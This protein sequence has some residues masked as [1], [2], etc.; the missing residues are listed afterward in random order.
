MAWMREPRVAGLRP[1]SPA[2]GRPA[3]RSVNGPAKILALQRL[4]GNS[5]V[6]EIFHRERNGGDGVA[7]LQRSDDERFIDDDL[8]ADYRT[9]IAWGEG[10]A[11][12]S[13]GTVTA[14]APSAG[15]A[16]T[17]APSAGT[18]TAPPRPWAAMADAA[19]AG[20]D[21]YMSVDE[22][23]RLFDGVKDREFLSTKGWM[24]EIP[25]DQAELYCADRASHIALQLT[26]VGVACKRIY[27]VKTLTDGAEGLWVNSTTAPGARPGVPVTLR[28]DYHVAVAVDVQDAAGTH[29]E[30]IFDPAVA[31]GG[32][33]FL[34]QWLQA[35]H[36]D[37]EAPH[38]NR[39]GESHQHATE[40]LQQLR[41]DDP[42]APVNRMG[43]PLGRTWV[44]ATEP[45][46]VNIP[47]VDS[48]GNTRSHPLSSMDAVHSDFRNW[49][50]E[51]EG[52]VEHS[53]N[54]RED[55]RRW[56]RE[57]ASRP[58]APWYRRLGRGTSSRSGG[59]SGPSPS[60]APDAGM[61]D[62]AG[63]SL[64]WPPTSGVAVRRMPDEVLVPLRR[65]RSPEPAAAT[66]HNVYEMEWQ[67][68]Q[69]PA[70]GSTGRRGRWI[71]RWRRGLR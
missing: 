43:Y 14:A 18:P 55:R 12:P 69:R 60:V 9:W 33:I 61:S 30:M 34:N 28:W 48:S 5:A 71:G 40:R 22:A 6:V 39:I 7:P 47:K 8:A 17:A 56:E 65:P 31:P 49:R 66:E 44:L 50:E 70:P 20:R 10:A 67:G 68:E 13:T 27:V 15:T 54:A 35:V 46:A 62:S 53:H 19:S 59:P 25:Y 2:P 52:Q 29:M 36:A 4:A 24:E 57:Q 16:G 1:S 38:M 26:S 32:P 64:R 3:P 23:R 45:E 11:A 51:L 37:T 21:G 63:P 58:A 42:D 41:M